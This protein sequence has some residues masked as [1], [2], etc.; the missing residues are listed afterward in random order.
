MLVRKYLKGLFDKTNRNVIAYYSGWLEKE[1]IRGVDITD[2][3]K[4]AFMAAIHK[5]DRTKGLDLILHTPGGNVATTESLLDYLRIMFGDNIRAI[6]PQLAM[7][8][9][10]MISCACKEIIMGKPSNLGPIDPQFGGIA[11]H[12]V[13]DEF[14]KKQKKKSKMIQPLFP[15]GR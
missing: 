12:G 6:I 14:E 11:A 7:S 15:F 2:S 4:N 1:G 13:I 10:T 9:G 5:F 3:D 8:A